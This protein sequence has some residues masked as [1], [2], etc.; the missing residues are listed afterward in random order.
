MLAKP[1]YANKMPH[2]NT[3]Y[4]STAQRRSV[5][6]KSRQIRFSCCRSWRRSPIPC[7]RLGRAHSPLPRRRLDSRRLLRL[8]FGL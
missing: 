5:T 2:E 8:V 6:I 1:V 7:S 3:D 4:P